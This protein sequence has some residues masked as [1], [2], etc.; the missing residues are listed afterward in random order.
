MIT[1]L[2]QAQ[3][4]D[5]LDTAAAFQ[6]DALVEVHDLAEM[7]RALDTEGSKIVGIDNRNLKTFEVD[8]RT[9]EL[10]SQELPPEHPFVSESGIESR[11]DAEKVRSW[12]ADAIP[13]RRSID[14][15]R[16]Y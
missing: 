7:E 12:G 3:L 9:T 6:L 16:K 11:A 10:L 15:F 4:I 8:L 13:C 14:A 5:L 2:D 1:T